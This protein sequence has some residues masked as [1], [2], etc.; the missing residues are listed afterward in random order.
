VKVYT[1]N[2]KKRSVVILEHSGPNDGTDWRYVV[3]PH[4]GKSAEEIWFK[5][6]DQAERYASRNGGYVLSWREW[7]FVRWAEMGNM[8]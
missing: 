7:D 4:V 6:L 2:F 1:W 5:S 3:R 8:K